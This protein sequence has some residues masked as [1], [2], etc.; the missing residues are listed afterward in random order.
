MRK[1]LQADYGI[2]RAAID[3]A[4]R[5]VPRDLPGG[6]RAKAL[7][8]MA[9]ALAA[10]MKIERREALNLISKIAAATIENVG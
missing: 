5:K 8:T 1:R 10:K 3:R 7:M 2:G 4:A 9:Q 6:D